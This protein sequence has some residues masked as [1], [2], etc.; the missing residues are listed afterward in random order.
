M[1]TETFSHGLLIQE[2]ILDRHLAAVNK[3]YGTSFS[4]ASG[5]GSL[6]QADP[7]RGEA[8]ST[9]L[10]SQVVSDE[11]QSP[12]DIHHQHIIEPDSQLPPAPKPKIPEHL[13]PRFNFR[14][15]V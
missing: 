3:A 11:L 14:F 12:E 9:A 5:A 7:I 10:N 13:K 15:N 6:L 1:T 4:M 2:S 8:E